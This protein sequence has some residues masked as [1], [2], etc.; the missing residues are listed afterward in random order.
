MSNMY[1]V[2][3]GNVSG[4]NDGN[5]IFGISQN[6]A[7]LPIRLLDF[8]AKKSGKQ[9]NLDWTTTS[10]LNNDYFNVERSKDGIHFELIGKVKGFGTTQ[11]RQQYRFVDEKPYRG[12]NYYRLNQ[13]DFDGKHAY[14][15]IRYVEFREE[16]KILEMEYYPNPV[17]K[18]LKITINQE[19][20]NYQIRIM[21]M[22]GKVLKSTEFTGEIIIEMEG[23]KTGTY[24][25]Q[26]LDETGK[27]ITSKKLIKA[28]L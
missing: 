20:D 19:V 7:N 8:K 12:L 27:V 3:A 28:E 26:L 10:E 25:L 15:P 18:E 17:S 24:L 23:Y 14:S 2:T 13:F 5:L 1:T 11:E 4:I 9:V 6:D 22:S 21:D 16:G